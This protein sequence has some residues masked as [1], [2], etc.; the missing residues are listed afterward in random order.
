MPISPEDCTGNPS[1]DEAPKHLSADD[2]RKPMADL[3]DILLFDQEN[4]CY[5]FRQDMFDEVLAEAAEAI[6]SDPTPCDH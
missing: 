6:W 5:R 2:D 4:D 1:E 3:S